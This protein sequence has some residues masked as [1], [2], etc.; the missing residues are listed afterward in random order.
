M[1]KAIVSSRGKAEGKKR[2]GVDQAKPH[3]GVSHVRYIRRNVVMIN[4][5]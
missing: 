3:A 2:N 1:G 5:G 4:K